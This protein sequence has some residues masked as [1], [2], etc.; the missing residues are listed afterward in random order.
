MAV[1][2]DG[3]V[4]QSGTPGNHALGGAS[5]TS[6]TLAEL[7]SKIS[8]LNTKPDLYGEMYIS[9]SSGTTTAQTPTFTKIAGTY[10][11]GS[12]NGFTHATGVLT[13]T[14]S[15]T[16]KFKVIASVTSDTNQSDVFEFQIYKNTSA[17]AGSE[18]HRQ[19]GVNDVGAVSLCAIVELATNDTVEIRVARQGGVAASLTAE[20]MNVVIEAID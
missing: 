2:R 3:Q 17:A 8:D 1:Y 6:S 11:S 4:T 9:S 7:N 5:H 13:Y 15:V 12:L 20:H 16:R 19:I 14:G 10:T 18:Q